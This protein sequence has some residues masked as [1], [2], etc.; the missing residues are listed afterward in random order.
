MER[1]VVKSGTEAREATK[2]AVQFLGDVVKST[3]GPGGSNTII[4]RD[5]ED[6]PPMIV[7]D[8]VTIADELYLDDECEHQVLRSMV[9]IAMKTNDEA[10][11]GTT[12]AITLGQAF[13]LAAL[14]KLPEDGVSTPGTEKPQPLARQIQEEVDVVCK[15]LEEMARPVDTLEDLKDV[16]FSSLEDREVGNVVADVVHEVGKDG[17][18]TLEEG[19]NGIIERE[20]VQGMKVYAKYAAPYMI[21]NARTKECVAL[22]YPILVSNATLTSISELNPL[23]DDMAKVKK[24]QQGKDFSGIVVMAAKFDAQAIRQAWNIS[25]QV[26]GKG[27][28]FHFIL[29]KVPS[30]TDEELEDIAAFVDGNFINCDTKYGQSVSKA[31]EKDLGFAEKIAVGED[32][33]VI[34]GGRGLTTLHTTDGDSAQTRVEFQINNVKDQIVAEDDEQFKKKKERRL[35]IL[36]GGVGVIKVGA[37][38][39]TEKVYLKYKIEDAKNACQKA[40]LDGV[41]PGGGKAL[42]K[43][44]EMED[45]KEFFIAD[46]LN[47]PYDTIQKN[48]GGDLD[49]PDTIIDPVVVTKAAIKNAASVAKT[50]ITNKT[51]IA[52]KRRKVDEDLREILGAGG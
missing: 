27:A 21:T 31:R 18:V 45:V 46:A 29:V 52:H 22:N 3:L 39:H 34:M 5:R 23:V 14:D 38:T 32:E 50:V 51:I 20:V 24:Q 48:A 37:K 13:A 43:I 17:Y 10:G 1:K 19:F 8:G 47:A 4:D 41:V 30:L 33:T 6:Y 42:Q 12:T 16:A 40:L 35:G 25:Q 28:S 26:K 49:I 15:K 11:D 9:E 44:S 7:N 36:K 2:N